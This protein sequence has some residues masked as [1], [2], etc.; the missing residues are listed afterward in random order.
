MEEYKTSIKVIGGSKCIRDKIAKN[1]YSESLDKF[2]RNKKSIQTSVSYDEVSL[3]V[4]N[5][6]PIIV[7]KFD[8]RSPYPKLEDLEI[9]IKYFYENSKE[10]NTEALRNYGSFI[11]YIVKDLQDY[12]DSKITLYT[13]NI[14]NGIRLIFGTNSSYTP[15]FYLINTYKRESIES[16]LRG[17]S[18]LS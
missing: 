14:S 18:Y 12:I 15:E 17:F 4:Y 8:I 3:E 6:L 5:A 2:L 16:L 10:N 11:H 9:T 7:P 13:N 1:L